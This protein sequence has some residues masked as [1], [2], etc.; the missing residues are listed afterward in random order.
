MKKITKGLKKNAGQHFDS[1]SQ[2]AR[3]VYLDFVL[4]NYNTE[5]AFKDYTQH[6]NDFSINDELSK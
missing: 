6:T 5:S 4:I 2:R 1:M 3:D